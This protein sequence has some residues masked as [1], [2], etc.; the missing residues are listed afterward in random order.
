[1]LKTFALRT[2]FGGSAEMAA[3]PGVAFK[4]SMT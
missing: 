4:S 1:M 3:E 2:M